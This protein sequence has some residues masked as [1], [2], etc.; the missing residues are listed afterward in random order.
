M[1][2]VMKET[3]RRDEG[4]QQR[5]SVGS[6]RRGVESGSAAGKRLRQQCWELPARRGKRQRS[7]KKVAAAVLG[8]A[9]AAWKAAAQQ[10]K[11]CVSSIES[12]SAAGKGCGGSVESCRCGVESGSM[13]G[14]KLPQ[15][16]RSL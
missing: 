9:G 11:G 1:L 14:E 5:S 2:P 6:C 8:A 15:L 16:Q 10:E 7:R 4:K 3:A 12:G 13:A